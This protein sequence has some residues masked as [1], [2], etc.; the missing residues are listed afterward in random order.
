MLLKPSHEMET[1]RA[2]RAGTLRALHDRQRNHCSGLAIAGT[3]FLS[4][5]IV[6]DRSIDTHSSRLFLGMSSAASML[7]STTYRRLQNL[8][9]GRLDETTT[10]YQNSR[11]R[12]FGE[13]GRLL[14]KQ[15]FDAIELDGAD[16]GVCGG[17]RRERR[18]E[19]Q[20]GL[21]LEPDRDSP[22]LPGW[23]R[24]RSPDLRGAR[25]Q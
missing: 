6:F 13:C 17:R 24:R 21:Q 14:A 9:K 20:V 7:H 5:A 15:Q 22:R 3:G 23:L 8:Q 18:S 11:N 25:C 2:A 1:F 10:L 16:T 12:R 19:G 4:A